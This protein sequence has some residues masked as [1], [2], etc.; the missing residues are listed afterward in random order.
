MAAQSKDPICGMNID[1][2]KAQYKADY[3]GKQYVFCSQ[4]CLNK[5]KQNP[6]Q[7]SPKK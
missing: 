4:Q 3:Q 1:P 6:G 7:Y 5:F 2:S